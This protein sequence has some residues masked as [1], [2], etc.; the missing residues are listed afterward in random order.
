MYG[1]DFR[2]SRHTLGGMKSLIQLA[3]DEDAVHR[4]LTARATIAA[5]ARGTARITAKAPGIISGTAVARAVFTAVD[6]DIQ[7]RWLKRDADPVEAG[8]A[9]CD[10]SGPLRSLLAA[11]RTALNFLQHLSGI[12]TATHAYVEAVRDTGCLIAD[13]RKTMPGMRRLEKEAVLHGGGV[14]HRLDLRSGMLIKENHIEACGSITRAVHACRHSG[15]DVRLE[16]ECETLAQVDEAVKVGPDMVLLDNM[17]PDEV[18]R[19]RRIVPASILL[20]ASGNITLVNVCDYARAGVDRIAIGAITHSAPA[21]DLSMR[22][23]NRA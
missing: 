21:L 17:S 16:V 18:R 6:V 19:A 14:N 2:H 4:D 10:L 3:L 22:V 15:L 9:I 5:D 23:S 7:S 20:E 13:T 1:D 8:D 11:E 12:A